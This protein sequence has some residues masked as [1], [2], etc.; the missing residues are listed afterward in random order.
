MEQP[1]IVHVVHRFS[2]G[3]LENGVVNLVNRMP[4]WRHAIVAL[5]EVADEFRGR[6]LR[7]DVTCIPLHKGPGHAF[8]LYPTLYR[9]FRGL[10]PSI[11]HTR[12]L[13]A[14]EAVVPAWA[15]RVRVR[16]HGEHGRDVR[17]LDL[18]SRRYRLVR[19]VYRP[20]VHHFV[21]LS[22]DIESYL[23]EGVGVAQTRLTHIYNG[24][25]A[26]RFRP[27]PS[28]RPPIPGC[29]FRE[30]GL[31]LVGSVGRMEAVKDPVNLARAFV[32]ALAL[33]PRAREQLR[34]V[35][36]GDGPKL[37]ETKR[38]VREAGVD[39]LVWFAG[40]RA[41][42]PDVLRGLDCFALPSLAEGISN[43]ILEAMASGL[44]VVATRVGGNADLMIEGL[45]GQLVPRADSAALADAILG[46]LKDPPAARR[47]GK[48]G[49]QHIEQHFS[50]ERMVDRY[51]KLYRD[52]LRGSEPRPAGRSS[53]THRAAKG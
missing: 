48:A 46:Y 31:F 3:G 15:A 1:L 16:V 40:E 23:R 7:E 24:V 5:T 18:K 2:V 53:T 39:E 43:T 29:P 19:R 13:A 20:F 35:M 21:A 6:L 34:L 22:R 26:E 38:V 8:G 30:P 36:V 49:R 51:E 45:T 12:N 25:D 42:V 17:D 27:A 32:A 50:V 33:A 37:A 10:R 4:D 9:L 28:G 14:L 52:L 44:P 47:H 11:V 41:D